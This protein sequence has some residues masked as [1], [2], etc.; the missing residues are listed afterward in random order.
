[1]VDGQIVHRSCSGE[2]GAAGIAG[3][4]VEE[5][6]GVRVMVIVR[7]SRPCA[8]TTVTVSLVKSSR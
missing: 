4:P 1:M 8:L 7:A 2:L 3:A 6:Q 5:G